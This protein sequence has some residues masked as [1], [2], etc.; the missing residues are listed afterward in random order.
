MGLRRPRHKAY[1]S[2]CIF[3]ALGIIHEPTKRRNFLIAPALQHDLSSSCRPRLR[4][5]HPRTPLRSLTSR[6]SPP[7]ATIYAVP[8]HS[9]VVWPS[10][11]ALVR[12]VG[13]APGAALTARRACFL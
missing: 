3:K 13:S 2:S 6:S 8:S 7:G 4:P 5:A 10:L 11:R 12:G 1:V 9:M